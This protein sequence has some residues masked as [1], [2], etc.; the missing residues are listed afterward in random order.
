VV[1]LGGGALETAVRGSRQKTLADWQN[2]KLIWYRISSVLQY[3][4]GFAHLLC[5]VLFLNKGVI[6]E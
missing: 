3:V 4:K 6:N 2:E 5:F 1:G